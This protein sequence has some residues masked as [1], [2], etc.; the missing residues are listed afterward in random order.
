M[1]SG[2]FALLFRIGLAHMVERPI[3]TILTMVGV[4]LG[5]AAFVS[6]RTANVEVL[7]SFEKTVATV[8][9][10]ASLAVVGG[11]LGFDEALIR[12]V[13]SVPGV[14]SAAPVLE[15]AAR[16]SAGPHINEFLQ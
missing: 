3:R 6:V 4:A 7:R 5:V 14:I 12:S 16:L 9:G 2:Y 15:I 1:R 8:A 10:S 11:E 13:R